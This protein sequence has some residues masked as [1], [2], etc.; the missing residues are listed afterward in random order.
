MFEQILNEQLRKF[1]GA[2]KLLLNRQFGFR[3]GTSTDHILTQLLSKVRGLM[4]KSDSKYVTL[5]AL[6]IKKAF[7]S[8]NHNLLIS[9][10]T[11]KFNLDESAANL[12]KNYLTNRC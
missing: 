2:Q 4:S 5:A 10:L 8:V 11:K 12:I 6:D 9:K 1:I 3:P 7:D